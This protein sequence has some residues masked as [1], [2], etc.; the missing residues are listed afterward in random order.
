MRRS[1]LNMIE[2]N[3]VLQV[4]RKIVSSLDIQAD[5][6]PPLYLVISLQAF[7]LFVD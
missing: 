7:L 1:W 4:V 3:E 2:M 6:S 5:E